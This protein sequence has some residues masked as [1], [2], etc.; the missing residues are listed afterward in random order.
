VHFTGLPFA[1]GRPCQESD[2]HG[3][4]LLG[5]LAGA[6]AERRGGAAGPQV[7]QDAPAEEPFE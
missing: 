1:V 5:P 4:A 2:G 6:V 7:A 3:E